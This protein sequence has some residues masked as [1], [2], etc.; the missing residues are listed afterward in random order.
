MSPGRP[1]DAP[2]PPRGRPWASCAS[3]T[4]PER[5]PSTPPSQHPIPSGAV[6][7]LP[8]PDMDCPSLCPSGVRPPPNLA[9]SL[10]LGVCFWAGPGQ[11]LWKVVEII[12]PWC[13]RTLWAPR[14]GACG[15]RRHAVPAEWVWGQDQPC[16]RP[17]GV[18]H[19]HRLL[20]S[21]VRRLHSLW[22]VGPLQPISHTWQ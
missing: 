22:S 8:A 9:A 20:G 5:W 4:S 2:G 6:L 1:V 16:G 15:C 13:V 11:M 10:P 21:W 7:C 3:P 14:W 12:K 18:S 19:P 17:S